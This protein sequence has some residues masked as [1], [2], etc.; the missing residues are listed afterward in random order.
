MMKWE[1]AGLH[2]LTTCLRLRGMLAGCL[3][4]LSPLPAPPVTTDINIITIRGTQGLTC[5]HLLTPRRHYSTLQY[6]L[7]C[8]VSICIYIA[9]YTGDQI[10]SWNIVN[11]WYL[12]FPNVESWIKY[13]DISLF[14]VCQRESLSVSVCQPVC[15]CCVCVTHVFSHCT[16]YTVQLDF[17]TTFE[18][19]KICCFPIIWLMYHVYMAQVS[20]IHINNYF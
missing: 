12:L 2:Y 15:V 16:L 18:H 6:N 3:L 7:Q 1:R 20:H 5:L 11:Q 19:I 4:S 10:S 14:E 8:L 13:W 9:Q 17:T